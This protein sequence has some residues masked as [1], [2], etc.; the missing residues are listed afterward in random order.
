VRPYNRSAKLALVSL[1]G[2]AAIVAAEHALRTDL[3]PARHQISEYARGPYGWLMTAAFVL[4]AIAF[5]SGTRA[6][7]SGWARV[8]L[9]AAAGGALALAVFPTQTVAGRVPPGVTRTWQGRVHDGAVLVLAAGLAGA[10]LAFVLDRHGSRTRARMGAAAVLALGVGSTVA[11]FAVGDPWPGW[12]Q[13]ALVVAAVMAQA[14]MWVG[15]EAGR[16]RA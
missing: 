2:F 7:R 14:A 3:D 10:V 11:L 15:A 8:G 4:W 12:R 5:L 13:R 1:V 9:A 16:P 6:V